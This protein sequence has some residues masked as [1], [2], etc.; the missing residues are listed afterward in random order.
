M[1][2]GVH[3]VTPA[4]KT[5][6]VTPLGANVDTILSAIHEQEA[7]IDTEMEQLKR[8]IAVEHGY[9]A[10]QRHDG[11]IVY[12]GPDVSEML[13]ATAADL[14]WRMKLQTLLQVVAVYAGLAILVPVAYV[15]FGGGK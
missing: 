14:E 8:L 15:L 10:E 6:A 13:R 4:G 5:A 11:T 2:T 9:K 12:V 7:H 1:L 3:D